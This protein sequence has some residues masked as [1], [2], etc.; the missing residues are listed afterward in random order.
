[1][2]SVLEQVARWER[3]LALQNNKTALNLDH[4]DFKFFKVMDDGTEQECNQEDQKNFVELYFVDS[5]KEIR[6]RLRARSRAAQ[7][8]HVT[9][10]YFS[11]KFGIHILYNEPLKPG[12]GFVTLWGEGE[13]DYI[14]LPGGIDVAMDRFK[15]IVSTERVDDFLLIQEELELGKILSIEDLRDIGTVD[16]Y[17]RERR[18]KITNDWFTK[19]LTA[20][21]VRQVN[22]VFDNNQK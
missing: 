18:R 22:R 10:V 19:T 12:K 11:R 2:F 4:V 9:L 20:K 13:E 7:T 3:G 17:K 14:S 21:T 15:L 8:L 1:M 6:A 5:G 16:E